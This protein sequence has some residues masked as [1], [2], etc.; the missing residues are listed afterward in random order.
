[1]KEVWADVKGYEGSYQV[2][3]ASN[4]RSVTRTIVYND[5][6]QYIYPSKIMTQLKTVKGYYTV[7][8][9]LHN[10]TKR[11][12]VHRL[13]AEAFIPNP[14]NKPQVNHK[15]TN[16]SNNDISNLE[17]CTNEE[18]IRHAY[19]NNLIPNRRPVL[20]YDL[21]GHFIRRWN[22]I[23]EVKKELNI[24]HISDVCNGKRNKCG[25]Y[26]WR[27]VDETSSD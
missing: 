11:C 26:V 7:N 19:N 23:T 12:Y 5:G 17:W 9:T 20:Q 21:E 13:V 24:N 3:N 10:K 4:V 2:S 22:S 16:K 15:D 1:M 14:E 25:G 6:R 8:L 27:Y 18:N